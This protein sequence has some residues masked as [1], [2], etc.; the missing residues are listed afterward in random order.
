M[1]EY[2]G[3]KVNIDR[4]RVS[5]HITQPVLLQSFEDEFDL[6]TKTT[7][8]PAE[9]GKVLQPSDEGDVLEDDKH[10]KYIS[11]VGKLLHFMRWSRPKYKIL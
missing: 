7:E 9:P 5:M 4:E 10:N 1:D 6:P 2:V 8:T 3:C 11:S